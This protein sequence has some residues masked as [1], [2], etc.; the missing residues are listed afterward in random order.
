ML[1]HG[2]GLHQTFIPHHPDGET[3]IRKLYQKQANPE[4][5]G[6]A[7]VANNPGAND[8]QQRAKCI[9]PAQTTLT[10]HIVN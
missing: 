2:A 8:R 3:D 4:M 1:R 9:A 6:H 5:V 7:I 10:H